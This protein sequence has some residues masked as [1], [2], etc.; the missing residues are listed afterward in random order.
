VKLVWLLT[1]FVAGMVAGVAAL[2]NI[3]SWGREHIR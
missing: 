1:A 3:A 2:W